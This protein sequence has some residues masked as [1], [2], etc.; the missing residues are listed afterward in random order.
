MEVAVCIITYRRPEGLRRL[1][2]A[3]DKL[4]FNGEPPDLRCIVVD[5][6][7][8][9]VARTICEELRPTFSWRLEA[10]VET[11]RGIP[12]ARNKA[13]RSA[14]DTTDFIAFIDDDE[15]PEPDWLDV[16]LRVQRDH[17]ADV[18]AGPVLP[19]LPDPV[20]RWVRAGGFF[21]PHRYQT[22]EQIKDAYTGNVL[23]RVD[24]LRC[25]DP[26]F[27]ERLSLT[28]G[29]DSHLAARLRK[30]GRRIVWAD[31]AVAHEMVPASRVTR[32]W[33]HQRMFRNAY[34]KS[35]MLRDLEPSRAT[36]FRL[37]RIAIYRFAKGALSVVPALFRGKEHVV[38]AIGHLYYGA[39]M[40]VGLAGLPYNEYSR[41]HG[42]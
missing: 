9:D 23:Y 32:R 26:V 10:Y 18:V 2:D 3:L 14:W 34:A 41:T 15:T 42:R 5:N 30:A 25:M 4:T 36:F 39:G 7:T 31:E 6:D 8:K 37:T 16:L 40:L 24:A 38:T 11:A 19:V 33:V 17:D 28:G 1:L 13:V 22:G 35:L 12:Q 20:P 29:S 21:A 27:D